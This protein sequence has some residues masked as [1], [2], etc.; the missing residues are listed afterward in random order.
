MGKI[1]IADLELD[2]ELI[3][4]G[5]WPTHPPYFEAALAFC[6]HYLNGQRVFQ[7]H[8]SG[9]TGIPKSIQVNRQQMQASAKATG[10]F[11]SIPENAD[12]LGCLNIEMIGGKMML[13]R[14]MEWNANLYL[15]EPSANPLAAVPKRQSFSFGAMVPMQL[16]AS[17]ENADAY[18]KLLLIKNLII[19]GAPLHRELQE[20]AASLPIQIYQTFGMTETV[21]HVA[22]AKIKKEEDL[23]YSALPGVL[24]SQTVEGKLLINSPM[25]NPA[26]ILTNDV[27]ELLSETSFIWKGRADFTINS[28]GVKLQPEV[29]ENQLA[30]LIESLFPGSRY[31]VFGRED[32][33]LGQ[34]VCLLIEESAEAGKKAEVLLKEIKVLISRYAA[35]KKVYF[36]ATFV[37]TASGKVNRPATIEKLTT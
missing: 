36:L 14:A 28:G 27:V 17:I 29:I 5:K 33:T 30:E 32:K 26:E 21:S 19:G 18:E 8:T 35:P 6:H 13:V 37:E 34:K 1:I 11:F 16:A 25:S 15:F 10:D 12:L 2:F 31:F 9:S 23:V 4:T 20:K 24:F 22:L 3:K 7:L